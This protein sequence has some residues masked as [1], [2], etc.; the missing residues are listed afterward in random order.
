MGR[1]AGCWTEAEPPIGHFAMPLTIMSKL[2]GYKMYD[3]D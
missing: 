3:I 2:P 1:P